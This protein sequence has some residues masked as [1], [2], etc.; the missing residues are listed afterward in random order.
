MKR[1]VK[2]MLMALEIGT[3]VLWGSTYAY[4]DYDPATNTDTLTNQMVSNTRGDTTK[5]DFKSYNYPDRNLVINWT[6]NSRGD[7]AAIRDAEVN[8]KNLT[9][10]AN[11][12]GNEWTDKGVISDAAT[13]I[14]ASGDINIATNNDSVYTEG[15]GTTTIEGFKNLNITS[16]I[17]G[18]GLVDNGGGITVSGGTG[19]SVT[20]KNSGLAWDAHP[21]VGNSLW[22]G[23]GSALGK[24]ITV[25]ADK[26]QIQSDNKSIFAGQGKG[27]EKFTVDLN[28]HAVDVTGTISGIG[29]DIFIN[30]DTNGT[31]TLSSANKTENGW[32][33]G[34]QSIDLMSNDTSGS[35]LTINKNARGL[36]QIL[37]K[38]QV[39]G[40]D[41][42]VLAN[43][44]GDGSFVNTRADGTNSSQ[45]WKD[46][47]EAYSGGTVT[48]NMSGN[49][50]YIR[51]DMNSGD[52]GN[53]TVNA[54]GDNFTMSRSYTGDPIYENSLLKVTSGATANILISGDNG[55]VDGNIR[56]VEKGNIQMDM[57]GE[58]M[59][60]TGDVEAAWNPDDTRSTDDQAS[61]TANFSGA[62]AS[63]TGS[64]RAKT[65]TS[66]VM[67][68]FSGENGN[69]TGDVES[70][71][72]ENGN[73]IPCVE[74][75]GNNIDYR[76]R[77]SWQSEIYEGNTVNLNISGAHASQKGNLK[78]E[79]NNTLNAVYSGEGASLTGNADN[80]GTMNLTFTN[81]SAMIGDMTNGKK[82]YE[83]VYYQP[84]KTVEGKLKVDFNQASVWTGNLT[85]T[86][87]SAEAVLQNSSRWT[88]NLDA[89]AADGATRIALQS[90]SAWIGAAKGNG[91]ISLSG[92]S[93]WKLTGDSEAYGVKL[94][95]GSII[96][97]EGSAAKLETGDLG[98]TGGQFQM[99]LRYG[100]DDV[101][102]YRDG[103]SSDFVLA[104]GGAGSTYT[105]AMT[106]DSSVNGMKDGS[107]LYFASTAP[108]TSSFK[109]NQAVQ[110]QN[111]KK[112][113]NKNLVVKNETDTV[114]PDFAG[115]DDWF[116]TPD[117][118]SGTNGNTINPNGTVPGSAY[119]AAFV[120]WRDDDTLLKRLGELRYAQEDQ[121]IWARFINKRMERDGKHAFHGNYKTL[122]VGFDKEQKTL[123]GGNWYYGGAISHLWGDSTYTDGR[124]EQKFTDVAIYG[125]NVRPHGH[126]LDLVARVG[127]IDSDY[128]TSYSDRG[129]F[130][131]WV[132][133][134][135]AEYGR[136]KALRHGWAIEPQAQMTYNY[137]WGDDYTTRNGAKVQQD[138]AD[139]LVGRLGFVL[140]R[141]FHPE[142]KNPSRVYFKA[143]VLHDFLGNTQSHIMDDVTF[144]DRDDL[145][146]T[147]YLLGIGTNIHFSDTTQFYL[148]A[149]R[150]FHSDIKMKYRFNAGLRFEF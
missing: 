101:D 137:L 72:G 144:T 61:I 40:E 142:T 135:S 130:K 82:V 96:S 8:A 12:S 93:L 77:S 3:T 47:I 25:K 140:S 91:D 117:S 65:S 99:D 9:I 139:S 19:S 89:Q 44:T 60:F 88:G 63:M 51:G 90:G 118:S 87:G 100:S 80:S 11:F 106:S 50:S 18:Y 133:S 66:N 129:E 143:S 86:T 78:A 68:N 128:E 121:G 114:N 98:G 10:N 70:V 2:L 30:S 36:V 146:D 113:Y 15:K 52:D 76:S 6:D 92:N 83:D 79:G 75:V 58:N 4:A 145:G 33:S 23:R 71:S 102:S 109:M 32:S 123:H 17:A 149:E 62:H 1:N 107:K 105:V 38:I 27:G 112:I 24:G 108:D 45:F 37:G 111:Y 103:S 124:G 59:A 85:S 31:V 26:I 20:I 125:T 131:N 49:N 55:K 56:A 122:Q 138:N 147:W 54:T 16:S 141:E 116:L 46:A 127:R 119:N 28:A 43:M 7:G 14:K 134:I 29:G 95:K 41:S 104:Q 39:G 148:D 132:S 42:S 64:I 110:I 126:Y 115:Y 48:L 35:N 81:Q 21:T 13:H 53:I 97:M 94:D 22:T 5:G 34:E 73:L 136:K 67:V 150:S 84:L 120:L 57:S 69:L 74:S